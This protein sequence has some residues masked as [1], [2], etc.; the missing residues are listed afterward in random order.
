MEREP[1]MADT[2]VSQC[3]FRPLQYPQIADFR[4][5]LLIQTV[6][7]IKIDL[8]GLQSFQ[9]FVQVFVELI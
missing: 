6:Q 2:A 5:L 7:K 8:F 4:P 3:A 1:E 9:L